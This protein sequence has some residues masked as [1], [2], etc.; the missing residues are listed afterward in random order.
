[1]RLV[2][3]IAK[4]YS[5]H[6]SREIDPIHEVL[7][8][9][10]AYGSLHNAFSALVNKDDEV[11]LIEPF[12]DCYEP[13]TLI[14]GGTPVYVPL[15]YHCCE[16]EQTSIITSDEWKLNEKDLRAAFN[17][18][19]KLIVF[20]T[21]NNPLGKVY[22]KEEMSLIAE[23]CVEYNVICLSD[24]VYE[25][26]TYDKAHLRIASFPGMWERTLTIGS[27]GKK[28]SSTGVKTGWTIGPK[29]LVSLC[30]SCNSIEVNVCPTLFQV[31]NS[32]EEYYGMVDLIL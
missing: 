10:G 21:P 8:T 3:A 11:I 13:M 14:A 29:E 15:T 23:L 22:T 1:M 32:L 30:A 16:K 12:Y 20:N 9:V 18:K 31:S 7:I 5:K 28:F 17:S 27:A 24:E 26:I 19:T 2:N 6:L 4:H 25:D